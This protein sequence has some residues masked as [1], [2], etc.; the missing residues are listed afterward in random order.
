ME[1]TK[2]L[3][4]LMWKSNMVKCVLGRGLSVGWRLDWG[5]GK[6]FAMKV[7]YRWGQHLYSV[8]IKLRNISNVG[9]PQPIR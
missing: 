4:V 5:S 9:R 3:E 2:P 7:L 8:D 1:N 6:T